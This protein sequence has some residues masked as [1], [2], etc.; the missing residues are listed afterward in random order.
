MRRFMTRLI[1]DQRGALLAE[2]LI[3]VSVF[4]LMGTAVMTG[5]SATTSAADRMRTNA[6]AD[7]LASNQMTAILSTPYVDPPHT[8]ATIAPPEGYSISATAAQ[9]IPG[10]TYIAKIVVTVSRDEVVLARLESLRLKE[11]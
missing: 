9:F 2:A 4:T 5:V 10:D 8:F 11:W 1:R 6:L 7:T 3:A